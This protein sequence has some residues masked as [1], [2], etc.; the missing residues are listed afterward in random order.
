MFVATA[1]RM[2]SVA[3]DALLADV[4]EAAPR[5]VTLAQ[6][7]SSQVICGPAVHAGFVAS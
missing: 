5:S 4:G 6:S 3:L 7:M 1:I 2:V